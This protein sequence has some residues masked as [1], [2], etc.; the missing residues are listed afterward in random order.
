MS[1]FTHD[2]FFNS[3]KVSFSIKKKVHSPKTPDFNTSSW[4]SVKDK[5]HHQN[6]DANG[7]RFTL[8]RNN[9]ETD[10]ETIKCKDRTV[11]SKKEMFEYLNK[12]S[13][14]KKKKIMKD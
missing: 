14:S 6:G 10:P 1:H 3:Q 5:S 9:A 8:K 2:S 7:K 12:A 13:S 11:S 4:E